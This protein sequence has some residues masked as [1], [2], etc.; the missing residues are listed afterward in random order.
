MKHSTQNREQRI[1]RTLRKYDHALWKV[2]EGPDYRQCGPYAIV[3]ERTSIVVY[4]ALELDDV[5]DLLADA[6][7]IFS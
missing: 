3:D 2:R 7:S 5:D 6:T 1:R 4:R